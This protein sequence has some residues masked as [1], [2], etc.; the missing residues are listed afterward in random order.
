MAR[1]ITVKGSGR[2]KVKADQIE[3]ALLLEAKD[4]NYS[5]AIAESTDQVGKV[6]TAIIVAGF[7]ETDLKNETFNVR[8][9]YK[10]VQDKEGHYEQVFD[11]YLVEQSMRLAFDL[12]AERLAKVLAALGACKVNPQLHLK[13]TVKDP[14]AVSDDLLKAAAS[15]AHHKAKVL[16]ESAKV[17][18]GQLQSIDYHF[19]EDALYSRTN[20]QMDM[21]A[22]PL[23]AKAVADE[24]I[25]PA[26]ISVDDAV[27]I[28]WEINS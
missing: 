7:E 2:A 21:E 26:D 6:R 18:L 5:K 22:A 17:K 20:F 8:S 1:T 27:T 28:V 13:F 24:A 9:E 11:G 19:D 10:H 15:D 4:K 25:A 12:D 23:M 3:I 16:C 14:Q